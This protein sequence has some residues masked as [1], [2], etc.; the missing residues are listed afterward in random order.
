MEIRCECTSCDSY[1]DGLC[2]KSSYVSIDRDGM[3]ENCTDTTARWIYLGQSGL[4]EQYMDLGLWRCSNCRNTRYGRSQY[5][6]SCGKYM[7]NTR[8]IIPLT[9]EEE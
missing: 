4:H 2:A 6:P 1:D 3:C 7:V 5:C 9:P 8:E